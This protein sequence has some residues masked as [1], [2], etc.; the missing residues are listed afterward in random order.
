MALNCEPYTL[1]YSESSKGWPSFY[2][3]TP[4]FMIGMNSFFYTFKGGN[5]FRHNTGAQRNT[6]YGQFS[7]ATIT[8]VFNLFLMKQTQLSQTVMK[9]D[10]SVQGY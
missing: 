5:L 7:N 1:S 2:S 3:F 10:G 6:Y 8:S 9:R 4:E